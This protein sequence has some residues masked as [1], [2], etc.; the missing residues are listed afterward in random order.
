MMVSLLFNRIKAPSIRMRKFLSVFAF[1]NTVGVHTYPANSVAVTGNFPIRSSEWK[2]FNTLRIRIG[3][4]GRIYAD[5][6][7]SE[8]VFPG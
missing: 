3:V 1:S 8:P 7:L 2:F 5:V 4:D 6:N